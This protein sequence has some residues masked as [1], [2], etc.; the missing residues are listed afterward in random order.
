[1]NDKRPVEVTSNMA[2][3]VKKIRMA[4]TTRETET[5]RLMI[6]SMLKLGLDQSAM[7]LQ[8]ESGLELESSKMTKIR[9]AIRK[10]NWNLLDT[11]IKGLPSENTIAFM[12]KKQKYI[13]ALKVSKYDEALLVLQK[14]ISPL[15]INVDELHELSLLMMCSNATELN[16]KAKCGGNIEAFRETLLENVTKQ[17]PLSMCLPSNRLEQLFD[18]A[19]ET[20]ERRCLYHNEEKTERLLV[21]HVCDRNSFPTKAIHVFDNHQDEV[22]YMKFSHDGSRLASASRDSKAIIFDLD[23]FAVMF[24]LVGHNKAISYLAWSPDDT[25]LLT[26]SNDM[27]LKLWDSGTGALIRN[28][29]K[30]KEAVTC[31]VWLP[32]GQSFVSGSIEKVMLLWNMLGEVIYKWSGIRVMDLTVTSNGA[33]LIASSEKKILLFDVSNKSELGSLEE[34]ESITSISLSQNDQFLLVNLSVSEIHLWDLNKRQI[35]KKYFGQKQGRFVIRSCFGGV[36]EN[37][38]L[39][40]SEGKMQLNR[41]CQ[42]YVWHRE[43]CTVI[44]S[45]GGHSGTQ[46][47]ILASVSCVSWNP[48]RTMF[49]SAADDHQIRIWMRSS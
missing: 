48:T 34:T 26:A 6:Q 23:T 2:L 18:Q 29:A 42:V 11:L 38:V 28:F 43:N 40:G 35:V 30:H 14:E 44:E 24:T 3:P 1:M 41:D 5:I 7:Q 32:S 13:E 39:S 21:D 16:L 10:G 49:A 25:M 4:Y 36:N 46:F 8:L 31:C 33:T 37:F 20:Q 17:L 15:L 22:W 19:L 47:L 12:I 9:G 45:L 27:T